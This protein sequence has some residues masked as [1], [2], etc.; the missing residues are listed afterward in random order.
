[1][2]FDQIRRL[3]DLRFYLDIERWT[4]RC[5]KCGKRHVQESG[6]TCP[7]GEPFPYEHVAKVYRVAA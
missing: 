7:C 2:D 1:M 6:R 3:D 4:F 5:L